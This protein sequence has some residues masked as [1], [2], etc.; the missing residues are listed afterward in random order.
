MIIKEIILRKDFLENKLD[1]V[2]SYIGSLGTAT[3]E[4]KSELYTKAI[5]VKFD[6]LSKI[7][8]HHILLDNLNKDTI[9]T[10]DGT[11]I[12]VYEASHLLDT[13]QEKMTTFTEVIKGD[14]SKSLD[15][16]T[17]LEKLDVLFEEYINIYLAIASSDI[18]TDWEK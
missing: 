6:L 18:S 17:L 1:V 2:D 7:R 15:V 12:S 5:N 9:L 8:S 10:I 14:I 16:F 11:E 13:L 4:I 3:I